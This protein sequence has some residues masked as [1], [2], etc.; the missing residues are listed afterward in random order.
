[1]KTLKPK[2]QTKQ[3][4]EFLSDLDMKN[5]NLDYYH[6]LNIHINNGNKETIRNCF[7]FFEK[8]VH[9]E[10]TQTQILECPSVNRRQERINHFNNNREEKTNIRNINNEIDIW[11]LKQKYNQSQLD[12]IHSYLCHSD[13]KYF[14]ERQIE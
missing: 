10:D 6:I 8:L 3:F 11:K 14:I 7:R 12:I 2:A 13:W 9:S 5:V 4:G 1:M